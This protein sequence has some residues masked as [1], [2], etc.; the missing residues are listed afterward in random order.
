MAANYANLLEQLVA[1]W[2][3]EAEIQFLTE[4]CTEFGIN[5]PPEKADNQQ[6]LVRLISRY[7]YSEQLENEADHGHS[8]WLKLFGDLGTSLGKGVP[9][10][11]PADP[12]A[13]AGGGEVGG[14]KVPFSM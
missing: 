11:E 6:Y 12:V 5:V 3:P 9:K 13:N 4:R 7:L 10:T 14:G 2:L 1:R 8:V